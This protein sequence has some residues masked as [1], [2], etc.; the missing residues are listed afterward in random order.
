MCHTLH[1]R[2]QC[3]TAFCLQKNVCFEEGGEMLE[4]MAG[5]EFVRVGQLLQS[6]VD[7]M[8]GIR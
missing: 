3:N 6:G 7:E 8:V 1:T 2:L 4:A 5:F